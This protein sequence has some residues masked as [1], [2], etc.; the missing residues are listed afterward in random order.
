MEKVEKDLSIAK[1]MLGI[2]T[3]KENFDID[4]YGAIYPWSNEDID[5]YYDYV[6]LN[7]KNTFA[8]TGSGDHI[9]YACLA[10][11]KLVDGIDINPF[12][13]YYSALKI[14]MMKTYDVKEIKRHLKVKKY[15]KFKIVLLNRIDLKEL[16]YSLTDEEIYF[17]SDL[18]KKKKI[19]DA[20]F[21]YDGF[22][23]TADMPYYIANEELYNKL[24]KNLVNCKIE[25]YDFDLTEKNLELPN[26]YDCIY[27]SNVLEHTYTDED[28]INV[29][30][31]CR[32]AL[33][34]DGKIITYRLNNRVNSL[35]RRY[36]NND[37]IG[38]ANVFSF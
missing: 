17:W 26:M 13:K 22:I 2:E 15:R 36:G 20:L 21:R 10:G 33:N 14:S 11:S 23:G 18:I 25:Y 1:A 6:D 7:D 29:I 16:R 31:N 37:I 9:I 24:Q 38:N 4:V 3:L 5:S 8:V 30:N 34:Q 28:K 19:N 35:L 27:L 12:A 32:D